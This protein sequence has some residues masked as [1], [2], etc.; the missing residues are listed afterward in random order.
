MRTVLSRIVFKITQVALLFCDFL[1]M[2]VHSSFAL[3]SLPVFHFLFSFCF[4]VV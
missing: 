2:I 3:P 4:R 1:V